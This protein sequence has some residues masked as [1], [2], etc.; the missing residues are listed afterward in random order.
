MSQ[1]T[2]TLIACSVHQ[3][4]AAKLASHVV[5]MDENA[6]AFKDVDAVLKYTFL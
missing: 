6:L 2:K 1:K 5:R 4:R 3:E